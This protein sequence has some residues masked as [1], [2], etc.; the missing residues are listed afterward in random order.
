MRLVAGARAWWR[1]DCAYASQT[2]IG[3]LCGVIAPDARL[4]SSMYCLA[5]SSHCF[6]AWRLLVAMV[7]MRLGVL[8][9]RP[10]RTLALQWVPLSWL[11]TQALPCLETLVVVMLPSSPG[12]SARL[13]MIVNLP[14]WGV[15]GGSTVAR[16][17]CFEGKKKAAPSRGGR[18]YS[19]PPACGVGLSAGSPVRGPREVGLEATRVVEI[20][21]VRRVLDE[22]VP[23]AVVAVCSAYGAYPVPRLVGAKPVVTVAVCRFD[24]CSF[25]AVEVSRAIQLPVVGGADKGLDG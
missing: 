7:R 5:C 4:A 16:V 19:L 3:V 8:P 10:T 21:A 17:A 23:Q 24:D 9:L 6:T 11:T 22:A 13:A 2:S 1:C 15:G 18:R 20:D 14:A 25:R 12:W